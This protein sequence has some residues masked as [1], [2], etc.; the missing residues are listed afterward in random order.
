MKKIL[1]W[2]LVLSMSALLLAGCGGGTTTPKTTEQTPSQAGTNKNYKIT[3]VVKISGIAWFDRM[4]VGVEK[5]AKDTGLDAKQ[6]G[7][8]KAD[9]ALQVQMIEDLI[10]QNV[11]AICVVPFSPDALEPVLKKAM[12]KG[13]VVV[14]HEASNL[15]NTN[16][17][18]E[19]FKNEDFGAQLMDRIGQVTGGKGQ[20]A[21]LVGSLTSKTHIQWVDG[22][23]AE[24]KAK[25]AGMEAVPDRMETADDQQTAYNKTKELLKKY[26]NLVAIEGSAMT[27]TPGAA[28][29][30]EE[31]GLQGKVHIVGTSLVSV[32]GKYIKDGTVDAIGFW[33][34]ADAGY[35][36]NALAKMILDGKKADIKDGLNLNLPGYESLKL[37]GKVFYGN[38]FHFVDKTNMDQF[39]F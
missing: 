28:L 25:F 39:N 21:Q 15:Q 8:N 32:A 35:A 22:A 19:A 20:Y 24:Q 30:V 9:A 17:D 38:A 37:D 29:A 12:D 10:A 2:L 34:P 36:M 33:D 14:S 27:D 6:V 3:T 23:L 11:N 26:P 1:S 31:M 13:I 7:P 4:N 18:I 5:F 16:Y